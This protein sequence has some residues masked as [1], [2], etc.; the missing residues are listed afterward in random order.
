VDMKV[1]GVNYSDTHYRKGSGPAQGMSLPLIPGHEG[2]GVVAALGDGVTEVKIGD[3]VVFAGQ[4]RLGT[5]KEQM[6]LPAIDLIP[7]PPG[8][9]MKLAVAVLNQGQTAH[10]LLHDAHHTK[11][12]ERVLIHAG[13]GGVGSNLV[14]MAKKLGAYVYATVSSEDKVDFVRNLG[15]DRVIVYTRLDFKEEIKKDTD[16]RGVDAVF[17]AIGAD[18]LPKSLLSLVSKGHL[19]TYGES[20]GPPAPIEWPQRGLGSIYLSH[21][22]SADYNHPGE[23]S[24]GRAYKI[25]RWVCD[26][27]LKV[28]IHKEYALGDAPQAHRDIEGRK[29]I[30]KLLLIP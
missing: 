24:I 23:E 14:Q 20:G 6:L 27:E 17:D 25:F 13:A 4:H 28:H 19:V 16:G 3:R 21:H 30:G 1:I 18:V 2:V 10:Y 15:A 8:M 12:G 11:P 9:D 7:L 22:T 29:T 5:Y 26:G